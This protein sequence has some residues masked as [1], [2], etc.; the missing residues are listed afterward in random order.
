MSSIEIE[1]ADV[2]RLIEQFL[3]ESNLLRTL[4]VLQEETNIT[5]NTVDN[6]ETFS[7]EITSGHWDSVLKIIQ[8]LKLPA[9]KL[10]DLYEQIITELVELRELATARLIAR[11]TDPMLLLKKI[12]PERYTRLENLINRPY[13]DSSE[14]YGDVSKD[15]RRYMIAQAL[16]AEVHVVAPSRLLALLAQSLK[17]QL[18]QGLLPPGTAIDLFR[19]KAALREQIEEHYPTQ[20]ARQI[21]FGANSYPESASFSPDGNYLVSGS[22]D[23]F[24][25]VWNYL[26][27]KLRK[28]LKY[29]AQDNLMMMDAAVLC[30]TFSRDSEMLATGCSDGKIKVWK[31][32]TGDCLRR[33]DKA[34]TRGVTAVRFSRDNTH[35]LSAGNDHVVRIHGMKSG[36]CLKEM[37]GHTSYVTDVRYTEEGNQ[38]ISCSADGTLRVWYLKTAECMTTFRVAGAGDTAV[39]NVLPIPK[40]EP[41]QFV[42]C[43]RSNTLY[44]VNISGQV[45]RTMTSGKRDKGEFI[46]CILSPRGEWAYAL[47]EDGVLYCFLLQAASLEST[48]PVC[49]KMP[50]G[51]A[52]HPHQNLISTFGEDAL[53]KLWRD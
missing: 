5:L 29:Q 26:N 28:D 11:Q 31:V 39:L 6:I 34:H 37:R 42:V 32:E 9:K 35:I 12:D 14:V 27:G 15:K 51:L 47:A 44:V 16:S 33:F 48:L 17:W 45:V 25:E 7:H 36:K 21:K 20:L 4:A 22:K 43:N 8:P 30:M 3:K 23:G 2:I 38:A 41:P 13:F 46:N 24:I 10:I 40:S 1:S 18:H 53:L 50:H 52:H 19:G 49:E